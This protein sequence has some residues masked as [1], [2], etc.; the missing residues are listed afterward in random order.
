MRQIAE[1]I[2]LTR[3]LDELRRR[4]TSGEIRLPAATPRCDLCGDAGFVLRVDGYGRNWG[5][6]C[7]CLEREIMDAKRNA[8]RSLK[9]HSRPTF[10]E[11]PF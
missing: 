4:V 11:P 6:R 3:R 8:D 1:A 9:G 2:D 5:A 7:D 10:D